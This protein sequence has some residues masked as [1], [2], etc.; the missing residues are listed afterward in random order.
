MEILN[1]KELYR[2]VNE[3]SITFFSK[4]FKHQVTF[5]SRLRTTGGR[6]I[7]GKK[8]IELNPK[9]VE[10]MNED[11]FIGIIKHELCHYHLHIEG[12]GYKHGD[13]EFKRLLIKTG[14]PRHCNPLPSQQ[15]EFKY[16]Y[17]CRDCAHVYK[18]RRRVN[19]KKYRCGRCRGLLI[20]K[21]SSKT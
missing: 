12:K 18:R 1:E 14:S 6:Y 21:G 2:L 3:L 5:N 7:P 13:Q 9:Y 19:I 15:S 4:P 17:K 11:E 20:S 10:E 8:V 16:I